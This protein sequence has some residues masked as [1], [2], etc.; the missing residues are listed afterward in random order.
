M[1]L[2]VRELVEFILRDGDI[3]N[4]SADPDSMAEGSRIHRRIQ[5]EQGDQYEAEVSLS[6]TTEYEGI[7][8][9]VEG[10][11][12]GILTTDEGVLVDEIKTTAL[13]LEEIDG[14]N[15]LH[16]GQALCYAYIIALQRSLPR[17]DVQ[18]TYCRRETGEIRR[19]A[20][21]YTFEQ[22]ETF[23]MDL[24]FQYQMW[25]E[26]QEDWNQ[27]RDTSIRALPFPFSAYRPGQRQLAASVYR[28]V[29]D[30][31]Q[32]FCQAPTGIGKTISTLYPAVKALG[33]GHTDKIFYLTAKTITRQATMDACKNMA[34]QGLRLRTIILTAKD[35][36]CFCRDAEGNRNGECNPDGCPYAKGHFSRVNDA[37]YD[38]LGSCDFYSR[39]VV[40]ACAERHRVCPFELQLDAT[41]WCDCIVGDYNYLFDPQVY[42]RRFF[43]FP[44]GGYTFLIDE[45]HNLVDR[46]REMYSA[47]LNKAAVWA[48]K[49]SLN[50]KDDLA[51]A[52]SALNR[53]FLALRDGDAEERV[54]TQAEAV[55][56]L[57]PPLNRVADETVLWLK[58]HPGAPQEEAVLSLYFDVLRYLKIADLYDGRY[59]S[60]ITFSKKDVT[61]KQFCIDP[62]ALL[63]GCL[64]KGR[65]AVFF[66]ATLTPMSYYQELFGAREEAQSLLLPSPFPR[67]NLCL[68]VGDRVSTRYQ[69]RTDSIEPVAR[70]IGAAVQAKKGNYMVFFPSYAYM[71]AVYD[72][73]TALFPEQRTV[74]QT[75]DMKEA[76]REAFLNQFEVEPAESL[77]GFCVLG[78]IYSEGIDLRGD[79]LIGSIVVGVGLPQI[80]PEQEV[81]RAYFEEQNHMGFAYAYQIP[82]M[83][84]VHQA[85]G[86]VIRGETDRG[87]V[88]LIDDRFTS[89]SYR[90]LFPAHWNGFQVVRAP[91]AV[92]RRMTDFWDNV[93]PAVRSS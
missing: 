5:K 54:V 92:S 79:R 93:V 14:E 90:R 32:L 61:V 12:D 43:D 10:R 34:G 38:L 37:L 45:A 36:I 35:K 71:R 78:G 84:K 89:F 85:A 67:D 80:C 31:G 77:L 30:E 18:L 75:T 23:Y 53:A 57:L 24:L 40:E 62:A 74:R 65:A 88:L 81:V 2:S 28:T 29:R 91:E 19:F 52:L 8:Y 86:R 87:L 76:E 49:K 50:K 48:V 56:T 1:R 51:R 44:R 3:D 69:D 26:M 13:L 68:L 55:D 66:S 42:L 22:L 64:S 16:W 17:L 20:R 72:V 9:T 11:A 46:A 83:N 82:G 63:A 73:F 25:A 4:R 33:E 47:A 58:Q 27:V 6:L 39:S 60:L 41:L 70:M 59:R 15:R 7:T 21:P